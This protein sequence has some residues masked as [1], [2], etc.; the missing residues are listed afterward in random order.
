M[1]ELDNGRILVREEL[2]PDVLRG[3]RPNREDCNIAAKVIDEM[4]K[5][6]STLTDSREK[7][8]S[9]AKNLQSDVDV[10]KAALEQIADAEYGTDT[11]KLRG[12]ARAALDQVAWNRENT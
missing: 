2:L 8:W 3:K 1:M 4:L 5:Q 9:L 12:R 11:P 6:R 7:G 10:M